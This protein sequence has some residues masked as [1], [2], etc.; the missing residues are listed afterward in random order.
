M[1]PTT[2]HPLLA[3]PSTRC[4]ICN[5]RPQTHADTEVNT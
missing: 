1:S 2:T 3:L 4:D 5:A